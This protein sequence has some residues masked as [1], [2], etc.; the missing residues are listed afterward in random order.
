MMN[1]IASLNYVDMEN[2][3]KPNICELFQEHLMINGKYNN[4]AIIC[5]QALI[6]A[7]FG[8]LY[9]VIYSVPASVV[10]GIIASCDTLCCLVEIQVL[11]M[12]L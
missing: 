8:P 11:S 6:L 7:F 1:S 5:I 2:D 12:P 4:A 10:F 3:P 9:A